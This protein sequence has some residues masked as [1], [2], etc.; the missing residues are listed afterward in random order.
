MA[1]EEHRDN[2][3]IRLDGGVLEAWSDGYRRSWTLPSGGGG[4]VRQARY[5]VVGDEGVLAE[6]GGLRVWVFPG[7]ATPTSTFGRRRMSGS[8]KSR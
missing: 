3:G 1:I 7:L 6:A 2:C 8:S 4:A 5:G